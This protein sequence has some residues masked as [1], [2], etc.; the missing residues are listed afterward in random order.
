[1]EQKQVPMLTVKNEHEGGEDEQFTM[2]V[3]QFAHYVKCG[4]I[5]PGDHVEVDCYA[6][7]VI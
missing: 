5:K 6:E 7:T 1:M 2:T 3:G 4:N